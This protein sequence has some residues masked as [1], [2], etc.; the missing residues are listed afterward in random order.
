VSVLRAIVALIALALMAVGG[1]FLIEGLDAPGTYLLVLGTVLL[2]A[3]LFERWRYR[4]S[5]S[6]P[7]SSWQRTDERFIDPESG[8]TLTVFFDPASGERHY[9]SEEPNAPHSPSERP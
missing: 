3:T 4:A 8:R 2:L 6:R 1:R 7:R 9:V 5:T